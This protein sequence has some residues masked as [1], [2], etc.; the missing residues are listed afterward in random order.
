MIDCLKMH[1]CSGVF[2]MIGLGTIV[3][4]VAIVV[5]GLVGTV[6]KKGISDRF[7]TTVMQGIGLSVMLVGLSGAL[8]GIFEVTESGKLNRTYIM[9]LIFSLVVGGLIGEAINIEKQLER[10]GAWFQK[11]MAKGEH[12]F[13][14]GFVTASLIYCVGAMAIVGSLEDGISGNASTLFAK[15]ILDG[16]SAVVFSATLGIGVLFSFI[17]VLVYQGG[18]TLLAKFIQP[19]MSDAVISQMSLVGGVLILAIGFNILE[20]RRFKVGNLLPAIF[21]PIIADLVIRLFEKIPFR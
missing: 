15:A 5:G 7:S 2:Q 10:L 12:G 16:V 3:N 19:W 4:C 6:A 20:I 1:K 13:A 21:V 9:G 18:I 17:P 14:N 11:N 8:Q